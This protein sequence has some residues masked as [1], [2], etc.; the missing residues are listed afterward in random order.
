MDHKAQ[1]PLVLSKALLESIRLLAQKA[2]EA[3]MGYYGDANAMGVQVKGDA[4]P[5]T[6]AD[7]AA[8]QVIVDGL[9]ELTPSVPILSEE[10]EHQVP[11]GERS[12]W[13]QYWLID[14][15]DG[16]K[17]FIHGNGEFTVNIALI[18]AQAPVLGVVYAP[19]LGLSYC[20]AESVSAYKVLASG[21][22]L[23]L[24]Q[25]ADVPSETRV[26]SSRSH[27]SPALSAYLERLT[28]PVSVPVGS[29]LKLCYLTDGQG[30][31]YPRLG[32]TSEWDIA[33]GQAVVGACGGQVRVLDEHKNPSH[34]LGYNQSDS[35]LNPEFVAYLNPNKL[36][37]SE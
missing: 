2:G 6:A 23:S 32:P 30:D 1:A 35:L 28:N 13:Y 18:Q 29:S 24:P 5:V 17:E 36:P 26:L 8:H 14:P 34:P 19:A 21:E 3:A 22:S 11:W 37:K 16:T 9:M 27:P 10:D 12:Q 33:A 7:K 20:G 25:T 15:L 31:L 4:T